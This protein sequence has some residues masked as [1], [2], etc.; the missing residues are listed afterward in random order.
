MSKSGFFETNKSR[1][2]ILLLSVL[3]VT[4]Y[5]Q[6]TGFTFINLD[7]NLYVYANPQ[8]SGGL[9]WQSAVWAFTKF[10][11]ANWHPLTWISHMI[12]AQIY[13]LN[14]G[15]HHATNVV[16]H[17]L[18]SI[19]AFLVFRR[20]TGSFWRSAIVAALFA[21][22]PAHVE[23]VAWVSE[24]KD[25][26]S[27]FFWLLAMY[28][29][30]VYA[31]AATP[32]ETADGSGARRSLLWNF[33]ESPRYGL[34]LI[35]FICGL[36][37]KP[38]LVTFPFVLLLLDVWPLGRLQKIR[39][40]PSLV[41]EKLPFFVLSG[42]S[43]YIT[44]VAQK[45]SG[46]VESLAYLPPATRILNAVYSYASYIG[47]VF[48]P[49]NLALW[50]PYDREISVADIIVPVLVLAAITAVC[51][52]QFSRR[53]YLLVGWLWYLGTLVPVIGIVQVG[54][55][56]L[57]DR[58]TYVPYFGLFMMIV[59][60]LADVF[61]H[62]RVKSVVTG[63]ITATAIVVFTVL[64]FSQ[65][66]V[67][68]DQES[69]YRHALAVTKDN[70]LI[71]QNLCH[72]LMTLDRLDEAE[73]VCREAIAMRATYAES[74]NTLGVIQMKRRQFDAAEKS[75]SKTLELSP[76]YAEVWANLSTALAFQKRPDEAEKALERAVNLS[77]TRINPVVWADSLKV[78]ARA[79]AEKGNFEKTAENLGRAVYA[80][81]ERPDLRFD[82]AAAFYE[83]KRFSAAHQQIE[84]AMSLSP[85][86]PGILNF[87][88]RILLAQDRKSEAA[89]QFEQALKLK[90]D[91]QEAADNLK[92][93]RGEK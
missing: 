39:E 17:L 91:F 10:H 58:Y 44:L 77:E 22:H 53:K 76:N 11:S 62:L 56:S 66:S 90:P 59:W 4:I 64:S 86:D 61:E 7:D 31:M 92:K 25:V 14:A 52:W 60:G 70:F 63:A 73:G 40:L 93:T 72:H 65:T 57:A 71:A 80:A 38:M 74:Y 12:D 46:A 2:A 47:M 68:R 9:S 83:L 81:P 49:R 54:G 3:V 6:T 13:G 27:T 20:F 48:Y 35:L 55:Q 19:L 26:L 21:V 69:L 15:G 30:A 16:F 36:M 88:G 50:Y 67:W 87:Y 45:S 32:D 24:R 18:N 8:V 84:A 29:Y 79:F 28:A 34:V 78:L 23:S 89:T 37:A 42:I 41:V 33:L 43:A 75:F 51:V 82:L 5:G 85:N 1:V